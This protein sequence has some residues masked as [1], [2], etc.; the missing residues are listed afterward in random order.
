MIAATGRD[1]AR[2][3]MQWS[4]EREGGFTSG[5][6]WLGVNKNYVNLNVAAQEKDPDS[7]L[8]WYRRLIALRKEN[9]ALRCGSFEVLEL[10]KQVF[11]FRRS[12]GADR[13]VTVV[14]FSGKPAK[15]DCRG[16]VLLDNCGKNY[17]DGRLAPW[18]ALV[19]REG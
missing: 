4:A 3:P 13:I 15:S 18:Q 14:N 8:H 7:V 19:L 2:T 17:F 12:D 6:P 10:G 9:D 11:S 1:N 5:T 16:A